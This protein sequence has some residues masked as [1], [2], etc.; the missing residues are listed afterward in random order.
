MN[1]GFLYL[2]VITPQTSNMSIPKLTPFSKGPFPNYHF[3]FQPLLLSAGVIVFVALDIQ[4]PLD[5]GGFQLYFWGPNN[6]SAGG[7]GCLGLL[8]QQTQN[9]NSKKDAPPRGMAWQTWRTFR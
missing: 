5:F 6:F 9:F 3:G 8:H 4:M 1:G 2:N 7:P